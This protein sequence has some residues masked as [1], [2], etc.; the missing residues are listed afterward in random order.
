MLP[1]PAN[2]RGVGR[3]GKAM[4]HNV[5]VNT[6]VA[7]A[8]ALTMAGCS[9][10]G[11]VFKTFDMNEGISVS[12]DA[13]QSF[14]LNHEPTWMTRPG[15]VV[16]TRIV[17]TEP[18]PEVATV[19]ANSIT[20]KANEGKIGAELTL[21]S[22]EG[23]VQL[24]ERTMAVQVL[25]ERMFRAC[26]AYANG[27][28]TGT[29]YTLL[30]NRF[31][32]A[33]VTVLF[34]EVMGRAFG[35]SLAAIGTTTQAAETLVK[36]EKELKDAKDKRNEA[37]SKVETKKLETAV[38]EAKSRLDNTRKLLHNQVAAAAGPITTK[39]GTETHG[40]MKDVFK[41]FV[42]SNP[43]DD[44]IAAC[45]V[46]LERGMA[47]DQ[48]PFGHYRKEILRELEL[49][50]FTA[51]VLTRGHEQT[52]ETLA[53][54]EGL[55]RRSALFEHCKGNL[56]FMLEQRELMFVSLKRTEMELKS[57]ELGVRG[58]EAFPTA[59]NQ[60]NEIQGPLA[61]TCI[62]KVVKKFN[63]LHD[64][65]INN[66]MSLFPGC[67]SQETLP[68]VAFDRLKPEIEGAIKRLKA[69]KKELNALDLKEITED[70]DC[71]KEKKNRKIRELKKEKEDLI[72]ESDDL[73]TEATKKTTDETREKLKT[74]EDE[75][76]GLQSKLKLKI[77]KTDRER[78]RDK[79]R[80]R[81]KCQDAQKEFKEYKKLLK[82]L[83]AKLK[84]LKDTT[85]DVSAII[86]ETG[87]DGAREARTGLVRDEPAGPG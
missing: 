19:L 54:I 69:A 32:R 41:D 74:L 75:I 14:I 15:S 83:H 4:S 63:G 36:L 51:D 52:L 70:C 57:A 60:C 44:Y 53:A 79:L 73:I 23:L 8:C 38:N 85:I 84:E 49:T 78:K 13:S 24:A 3:K 59:I 10:T 9:N 50:S 47:G 61:T 11:K 5:T 37:G 1:G 77:A 31:D 20:A 65:N 45:M 26:E 72:R 76:E 2:E 39:A 25:R 80:L 34:G 6:M 56:A 28:I 30:I 68:T 16:P 35:R 55:D 7:L 87:K 62:K 40:H 43:V 58:L 64:P 48:G 67:G 21:S 29:T 66:Q 12:R 81:S 82:T 46:E 17:C 22:S 71:E 18:N 42:E 27:A 86:S 33:M